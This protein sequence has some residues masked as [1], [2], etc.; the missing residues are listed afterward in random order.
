MPLSID[1][2]TGVL[3][4]TPESMPKGEPN[5]RSP[6]QDHEQSTKSG[7]THTYALHTNDVEREVIIPYK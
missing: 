5:A 2:T 3:S 6:V 1:A 4:V 7:Y